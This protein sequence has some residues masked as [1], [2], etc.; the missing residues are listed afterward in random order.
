MGMLMVM[1]DYRTVN[2]Y[3]PHRYVFFS[4]APHLVKTTRNCLKSSGSGS[5]TRY[6]WNNGQYILW[7]HITE[8]FYQDIDSGLKLLPKLTYEHVNLNAYSVMQMNLAAQVLSASVAAV[9]KSFGP[10]RQQPQPNSVKWWT[11]SLTA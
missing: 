10:L 5:C 4:D 1:C 8:I 11:A 3:V 6:I 7:Q 2:L 9:L